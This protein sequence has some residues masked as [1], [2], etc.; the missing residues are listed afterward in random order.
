MI[1]DGHE[2]VA[3]EAGLAVLKMRFLQL[4]TNTKDL[5]LGSFYLG[6]WL[7]DMSQVIDPIALTNL[8]RGA[9]DI[10]A[11]CKMASTV[12]RT[13]GMVNLIVATKVAEVMSEWISNGVQR[14]GDSLA[15]GDLR[16]NVIAIIKIV[17]YHKFVRSSD[18]ALKVEFSIYNRIFDDYF[19]QYFPHEHLDRYPKD[20][21]AAYP[22]VGGPGYSVKIASGTNTPP[23][24]G[25]VPAGSKHLYQYLVDDTK[26]LAAQLAE[27][28]DTWAITYFRRGGRP[29]DNG[30]L[31]WNQGLARLGRVLHGVEDFFAHSN[32]VEF[33]LGMMGELPERDPDRERHLRR[34]FR[35]DGSNE[36]HDPRLGHEWGID[37]AISTGY[38]DFRDT[39][40]SLAHFF[41]PLLKVD[42]PPFVENL[43]GIVEHVETLLGFELP[44]EIEAIEILKGSTV[45]GRHPAIQRAVVA[46]PHLIAGILLGKDL[47]KAVNSIRKMQLDPEQF[48]EDYEV[49]IEGWLNLG[50]TKRIAA[51]VASEL[52]PAVGSYR[53][54]SHSLLSKDEHTSLYYE[55]QRHCAL[56][57]H[58]YIVLML[59]RRATDAPATVCRTDSSG[60]EKNTLDTPPWIDWL[61]LLEFFLRHPEADLPSVGGQSE[62][63]CNLTRFH[64]VAEGE[65]MNDV[66]EACTAL[67]MKVNWE[68]IIDANP[69]CHGNFFD[70]ADVLASWLRP[71]APPELKGSFLALPTKLDGVIVDNV[72]RPL[73]PSQLDVMLATSLCPGLILR[74][75]SR[76]A[77]YQGR[78]SDDGTAHS[79]WWRIVLSSGWQ[80]LPNLNVPAATGIGRHRPRP[81]SRDELREFYNDVK[82]NLAPF[83]VEAYN[84]PARFETP[85]MPAADAYR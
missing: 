45:Q 15:A 20:L 43:T 39:L 26:L 2:S 5:S 9:R 32:F 55:E 70:R 54:G 52:G 21:K 35:F 36:W 1:P 63:E 69:E 34:M 74:M 71:E 49:E 4:G 6:N 59:T 16:G 33:A 62:V 11:A 24:E 3:R 19:T 53:V 64:R 37:N 67:G 40:L 84:L 25:G 57:V 76:H 85:A 12:C 30:D 50:I 68:A 18:P 22:K 48:A 14:V 41:E 42:S 73:R 66:V 51:Y 61:Q 8:K 23:E 65:S 78:F 75:P 80:S 81:I 72:D 79:P 56:A 7:A 13:T 60:A 82:T 58:A 10:A 27:L 17:G 28:D 46:A 44:P 83:F 38:F 47:Y 31:F 29:P 77:K